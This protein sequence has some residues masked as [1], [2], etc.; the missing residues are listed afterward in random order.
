MFQNRNKTPSVSL[1]PPRSHKSQSAQA[2]VVD[3]A[4]TVLNFKL[5]P[6]GGRKQTAADGEGKVLLVEEGDAES[7]ELPRD[8]TAES[9]EFILPL[10]L[11]GKCGFLGSSLFVPC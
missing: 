5:E 9:H 4:A 1:P 10:A 3:G 11:A 7:Y 2:V 6:I 8:P